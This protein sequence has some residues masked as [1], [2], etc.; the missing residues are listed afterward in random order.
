[1]KKLLVL[2]LVVCSMRGSAQ[3]AS[4][5]HLE[6]EYTVQFGYRYFFNKLD[7]N[8]GVSSRITQ[9]PIEG[10]FND[11]GFFDCYNHYV[12][13]G[14]D[15]VLQNGNYIN[16]LYELD[17]LGNI[18]RALPMDTATG[19]WYKKCL[20]AAGTPFY[21]ALRWNTSSGNWVLEKINAVSGAR[22]LQTLPALAAL[23]YWNSDAA[24]TR[25][26]VLWFG[27][28]DQSLGTSVLVR[29]DPATGQVSFEDTLAM[30]SNYYYDCLNYDCANDTIYGFIAHG[31]TVTGSEL[32]K[33]HGTSGTVIYSGRTAIGT[34]NDRFGSGSHA[35]TTD[36]KF[37]MRT[38]NATYLLNNFYVT[39]PAFNLPVISNPSS[40]SV[41]CIA[42]PRE[43]CSFY[44]SCS[45]TSGMNELQQEAFLLFPNPATGQFTWQ[46]QQPI[47]GT[48]ALYDIA[49][50]MVWQQRIVNETRGT[51]T[52]A[53]LPAGVYAFVQ[54]NGT[55]V[56][57]KRLVVQNK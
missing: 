13:Q 29:V 47:D 56:T 40:L 25:D 7:R 27:M 9:L 35:R 31:D 42:A 54:V 19:T 45:E 15:S 16:K 14:I 21:F 1:M 23:N 17:T 5:F 43:A 49:G 52:T 11:I 3:N 24:I 48:L 38:F 57:T 20:P 30:G 53:G 51:I 44:T 41:F 37:Y 32:L 18:I 55:T 46:T 36:G 6:T 4:L 22:T 2:L 28:D 50:R 34:Q 12:F 39:A 8:T 10:Y 26:D 33:I